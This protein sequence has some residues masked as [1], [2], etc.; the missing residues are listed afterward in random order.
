VAEE[1]LQ[2][3][4]VS[5]SAR[6]PEGLCAA[7]DE[8]ARPLGAPCVIVLASLRDLLGVVAPGRGRHRREAHH[9]SDAPVTPRIGD[10]VVSGAG[11][12]RNSYDRREKPCKWRNLKR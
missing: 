9:R 5:L 12:T 3:D 7:T 4:G 2:R 11:V 6:D 10:A 1:T 8:A